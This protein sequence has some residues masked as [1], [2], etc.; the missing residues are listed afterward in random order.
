[1]PVPDTT[2]AFAL[3]SQ[4]Q[5]AAAADAFERILRASPD[6]ALAHAGLGNCLIQLG[7][8]DAAWDSLTRACRLSDRIDLA[9]SDLAWLAF[10]RG[11]AMTA[12]A[13]AERALALNPADAKAHFIRAQLLFVQRRFDEADTAFA[14]AARLQPRFIE[15]RF[16]LGNR[17]YESGDFTGAMRHYL[18]YT[19]S[20]PQDVQGWINLGLSCGRSGE[21][22]QARVALE[23]A[24]ALAPTLPR[25]VLLLALVLKDAGASDAEQIPVLQRAVELAPDLGELHLQ[26]ACCLCNTQDLVQAKQH[27]RRV[28]QI[29][30]GNLTARW[31]DFQTPDNALQVDATDADAFLA[32]W[33][34]GIAY[35]EAL[36]WSSPAIARQAGETL[37]STTSFYLA[38]LAQPLVAEQVRNARV[39]RRLA[40]AAGWTRNERTARAIGRRRRKVAVV[41]SALH[42]Q[43]ISLVWSGAF[44]ALDPAE[45]E[46]GVF[47]PATVPDADMQR[48]REHAACIE[49]GTRSVEAW[50]EALRAFAPDVT[51]FSDI[52][53]NRV[54]QALASVRHAPVQAATW[55]H[56]VT[57]GMATIDYFL[58]AD[59]CEPAN[60][61]EHYSEALVRLPRLGAYLEPPDYAPPSRDPAADRPL[62][63]LCAQNAYKLHRGHDALF[64]EI[65]SAAPQ[66]QLDI[67][68][69]K[70]AHVA[71]ALATRMR[72]AFAEHGI[73]FDARCRIHPG[74]PLETYRNFL[75][76]ADACLDALDFSGCITS[77]DALWHDVAIVTLPGALMRGRQT[78]GMLRLLG[79]DELIARDAADYVRIAIRLVSDAEW[80]SALSARIAARKHELYRDRTTV[81]ALAEFLRSVE[82]RETG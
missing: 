72:A 75:A 67:L 60:A 41:A 66:A 51:V 40:G 47:C 17:A 71:A 2:D 53:M 62:R 43:S 21:L 74:Q 78:Y 42:A 31:L 9:F 10:K 57:S 45:F 30:P 35:F 82:P 25:P 63:L 27:L 3:L 37:T 68:C 19:Q 15:A 6:D 46:L 49:T 69:G 44:R 39:L 20:R 23:R 56:P 59:A 34:D 65:L 79:L 61:H 77:L 50:I 18:A 29:D 64:A 58:S 13:S 16:N 14:H 24:I 73:D 36:G 81:E 70:P 5:V 22:A 76:R 28:Q 38:Y 54:V 11:D 80:R 55:A 4:G 26:L 32:H 1:M 8:E 48:W 33:R 7:R 52:G 12:Q